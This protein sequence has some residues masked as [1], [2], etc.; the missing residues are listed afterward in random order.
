[1]RVSGRDAGRARRPRLRSRRCRSCSA[2]ATTKSSRTGATS[3]CAKAA[4]NPGL[5]NL[6]S[7]Y[8]ERKPQLK[9]SVD[10]NRAA[11]LGV[12]LT[13][14][15][16]TLETMMGS[17]IVTTFLDR[18]EEYN[19]ILQA[20]DDDRATPSDL[21]NIYV[22]SASTGALIPLVE[23]RAR[24]GNR[25]AH[26]AASASTGCARSRCR[27]TSSPAIR[28]ARRSTT[29][30]SWCAAELPPHAQINYDGESREFKRS[31]RRCTRRSCSRW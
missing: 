30:R 17:R 20:R 1:M 28:W 2:A 14:V 29:W 11:D 27:R 3:C 9:V 23:P 25:R 22:R 10:R 8:Y 24:R 18:G 15:G 26:R 5:T 4:E 7:D 12:S 16:R 19:V 13:T 6:D 21:D 31:G